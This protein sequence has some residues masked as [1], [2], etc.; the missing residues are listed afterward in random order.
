[1]RGVTVDHRAEK[2]SLES[3]GFPSLAGLRTS[4][5]TPEIAAS[6]QELSRNAEELERLI[7]EFKV[8]P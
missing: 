7:G 6:A 3:N 8:A 5:S 4:A 2:D 1:V